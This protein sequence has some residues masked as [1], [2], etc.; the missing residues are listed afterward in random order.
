MRVLL[1]LL[2]WLELYTLIQLGISTSALIALVW[3]FV[4]LCLG[5]SLIQ[6]RGR[7]VMRQLQQPGQTFISPRLLGDEMAL[8]TAGLLLMIPGLITDLASL[9][10]LIGPL[11]RRVLARWRGRNGPDEP[12]SG[13]HR[14]PS[15]TLDGEYQRLDD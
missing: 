12:P 13:P 15:V 1:L 9:V 14:R 4:S 2:P 10:L 8:F 6:W 3:V 5:L 11:R 7:E